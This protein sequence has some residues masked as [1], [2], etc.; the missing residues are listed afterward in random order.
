[1]PKIR[2]APSRRLRHPSKAQLT[3]EDLRVESFVTTLASPAE[4]HAKGGS[5]LITCG[6][7]TFPV[8]SCVVT[9]VFDCELQAG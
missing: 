5:T 9:V 1:M 7:E 4:V 6:T 8:V 2:S 3:L